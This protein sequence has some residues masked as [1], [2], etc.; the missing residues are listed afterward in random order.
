MYNESKKQNTKMIRL[1]IALLILMG[2]M[3]A[4]IA[5]LTFAVITRLRLD[6]LLKILDCDCPI[7]IS[8][9]SC[10]IY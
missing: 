8:E 2:V 6:H 9:S 5:G 10:V 1:V 3:L 4:C 7:V